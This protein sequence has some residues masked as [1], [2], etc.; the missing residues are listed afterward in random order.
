MREVS[1][2]AD[3]QLGESTGGLD[4]ASQQRVAAGMS[5]H[6]FAAMP[7]I[8]KCGHLRTFCSGGQPLAPECSHRRESRLCAVY[9]GMCDRRR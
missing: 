1:L 5:L 9:R 2:V 6:S 3:R 7:A 4:S 8:A